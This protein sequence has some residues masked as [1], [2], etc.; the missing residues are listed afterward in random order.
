MRVRRAMQVAQ[1]ALRRRRSRRQRGH[2]RL[3]HLHA[4]RLDAHQ[5]SGARCGARV[6][7]RGVR[8]SLPRRR[9]CTGFA[10][11]PRTPTKRSARPRFYR[12]PAQLAHVLKRDELRLYTMIWERF[13][14][15]QMAAAVFDQTTVDVR[16]ER[17]RI[18]RDRDRDALCRLHPRLR[19]GQGRGKLPAKGR[20][21]L[22]ELHEGEALDCRKLEPKQHFTEPPPR[23]TEA[24]LVKAL[25]DNGIGRPSTYSTIVETI[26]ARGYVTQQE[27]RFMPTE[28][29][30]AVNDLLVEHFPKIL[31][32]DFTAPMEGDLDKSRRGAR[33]LGRA[34][35]PL[36]RAVRDRAGG[37]REEAAALGAARRADRRDLP[38][39]R[40]AD[41][42][43]DRPLRALHLVHRVS[44]MQDDQADR[45]RDRRRSVRR[46]AARSSS[47]AR[48]KG[49][50]STAARTIRSAISSRGTPWLRSAARSA[51][52]T[53][54]P[55]RGAA[56]LLSSNAR[57]TGSMTIKEEP[58]LVSRWGSRP[59]RSLRI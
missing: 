47:G 45:Q 10:R 9:A 49:A 33:G 7:R 26:Q 58:A 48:R 12:T 3:D 11:A 13:V 23:Y 16:R 37:G 4:Y 38:E 31:N 22:P 44:R 36:L 18:P 20:V 41:G 59:S 32:L 19:G 55:R 8:R 14:A 39:L 53:S 1:S 40:A 54:S 6:H 43:Q 57:P 24:A 21:R 51:T 2:R 46:A 34:A 5:R 15:S 25:E 52:P 27:R 30:I 42:H 35:A 50:R 56:A 17:V 29:G 28:I